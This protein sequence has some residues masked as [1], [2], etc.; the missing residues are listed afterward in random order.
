M[1]TKRLLPLFWNKVD[2]GSGCPGWSLHHG[3]NHSDVL[4]AHLVSPPGSHALSRPR[5]GGG[6]QLSLIREEGQVA[7]IRGIT[8]S[9]EQASRRRWG[10]MAGGRFCG[11]WAP[12]TSS[13]PLSDFTTK[14]KILCHYIILF[15]H[16]KTKILR[17]LGLQLQSIQVSVQGPSEHRTLYTDPVAPMG[18]GVGSHPRW[19][20]QLHT[21][22][23]LWRSAVR[24]PASGRRAVRGNPNALG[25]A[26][27]DEEARMSPSSY[28]RVKGVTPRW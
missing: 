22:R 28:P 10:D 23:M 26:E 9:G 25:I 17:M 13:M 5:L 3:G 6:R 21:T 2:V 1:T 15:C 11:N 18:L 8:G 14:H 19:Y 4:R 12:S 7:G 20:P 24:S 16:Y 27:P